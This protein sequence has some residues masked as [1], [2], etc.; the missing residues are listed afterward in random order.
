MQAAPNAEAWLQR[1]FQQLPT[2]QQDLAFAS[3]GL[4]WWAA[5]ATP[6]AGLCCPL[7]LKLLLPGC[8]LLQ[9]CAATALPLLRPSTFWLSAGTVQ[10]MPHALDEHVPALAGPLPVASAGAG[11]QAGSPLTQMAGGPDSA[12]ALLLSRWAGRARCAR[13]MGR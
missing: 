7:L 2:P 12:Q 8:G 10:S 6:A 11:Q 5:A 9:P 1:A 4:L 3:G 13:A